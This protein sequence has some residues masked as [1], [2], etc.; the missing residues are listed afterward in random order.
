MA[1][2]NLTIQLENAID[3]NR[4]KTEAHQKASLALKKSTDLLRAA[5]GALERNG[6][7]GISFEDVMIALD[8]GYC[9]RKISWSKY[10]FIQKLYPLGETDPQFAHVYS[11]VFKKNMGIE[12]VS[13]FEIGNQYWVPNEWLIFPD[14]KIREAMKEQTETATGGPVES[15]TYSVVGGEQEGSSFVVNEFMRAQFMLLN[16]Y[17]T[18]YPNYL[19]RHH[20]ERVGVYKAG[21]NEDSEIDEEIQFARNKFYANHP[22]ENAALPPHLAMCGDFSSLAAREKERENYRS[23]KVEQYI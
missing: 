23:W 17:G 11:C 13:L 16:N 10:W 4:E 3:N 22:N 8:Q 5:E 15:Q 2:N 9:A 18:P 12:T 21:H 6:N 19:C 20:G 14:D 1:K 7:G